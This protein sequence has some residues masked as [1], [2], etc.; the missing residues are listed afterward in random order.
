MGKTV[1]FFGFGAMG[2]AI[3]RR[4]LSRQY[5]LNVWNRSAEK[6]ISLAE[7]GAIVKASPA[8]AIR[9]SD[10]IVSVLPDLSALQ[11]VL[12]DKDWAH[13]LHGRCIIHFGSVNPSR[14]QAIMDA[15]HAHQASYVEVAALGSVDDVAAGNLQLLIGASEEDYT[16]VQPILSD[17]SDQVRYIGEVGDAVAMKLAMQQMTA[18]VFCAFAAS[19]SLVREQG[20]SVDLFM[21]FLRRSPLYSPIFDQ[22]LPRLLSRDYSQS[23]LPAKHLERELKLFLEEAEE[24][25]FNSHHVESIRDL[26][27]F[28]VARGMHDMDFT[29]VYDVINPPRDEES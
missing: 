10:T 1:T 7:S 24:L 22:K 3:A 20:L 27:G 16:K 15:F 13:A 14:S 19:L 9:S 28:C 11:E 2:L 18:T 25:G 17:L 6:L 12:F 26:I 5:Q 29:A 21:E 23:S 4:L 8:E